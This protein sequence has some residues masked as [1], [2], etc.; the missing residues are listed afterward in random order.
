M[1]LATLAAR[2]KNIWL[3]GGAN[4]VQQ[5]LAAKIV[6]ELQI[7]LV[8]VLLGGGVP[9]FNDKSGLVIELEKLRIVESAGVTHIKYRVQK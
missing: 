8:H 6:D 9:L 5:F 1:R 4:L 2:E 7:S 3:L